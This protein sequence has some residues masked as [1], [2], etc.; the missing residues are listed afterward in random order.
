[1]TFSTPPAPE[2]VTD[3]GPVWHPDRTIVL[4]GLMGAGKSSIGR[5]LAQRLE[6][7]FIDAD[8]E[9]EA[10]AGCTIE[11]IFDRF[12]ETAFRDGER[13]VI[14]RLLDQPPHVLATGG[15]AFMD[16]A[17]RERVKEVAF[18]LWLHADIDLL[19]KRVGRRNNRPLLK[20]TDPR[21]VLAR[22]MEQRYPVYAEADIRIDS[23]D[24]PP[25][26]TVQKAVDALQRYALAA[27]MARAGTAQP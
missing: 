13:R 6:L 10:A 21:T 26:H 18:S 2:P 17:V 14:L 23:A 25:E 27:G 15:G 7:P 8:K 12:G 9:I 20:D 1:M 16:P 5:R 3:A 24:G 4:V 11:E 19:L 22:L